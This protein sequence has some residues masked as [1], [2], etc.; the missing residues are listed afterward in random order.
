VLPVKWSDEAQHDL[1]DIQA[2]IAQ[3]SPQAAA[4]LRAAIEAAVERLARM[5]FAFR[6][7]RVSGT[8]E[9]VVHP[10]YIVIYRVST[11]IVEVLSIVHAR[12]QY[13]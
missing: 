7:G 9:Y 2:Y 3:F 1:A 4:A 6:P 10:N 5:P 8:R 13:P 11:D 12:R